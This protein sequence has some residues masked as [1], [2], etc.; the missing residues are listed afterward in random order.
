MILSS[1]DVLQKKDLPNHPFLYL[2]LS[3]HSALV[4]R[5]SSCIQF[6]LDALPLQHQHVSLTDGHF[7]SMPAHYT[8]ARGII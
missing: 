2:S 1:D 4:K 3:F 7:S 6:S 5:N 8:P